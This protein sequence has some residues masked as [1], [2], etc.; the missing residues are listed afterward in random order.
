MPVGVHGWF[1]LD[2]LSSAAS[3]SPS[4]TQPA[5]KRRAAAEMESAEWWTEWLQHAAATSAA[6]AD[7]GAAAHPAAERCARRAGTSAHSEA[8]LAWLWNDAGDGATTASA[9]RRCAG[10]DVSASPLAAAAWGQTPWHVAQQ[11]ERR[12]RLAAAHGRAPQGPQLQAGGLSVGGTGLEPDADGAIRVG[13]LALRAV[14]LKQWQRRLIPPHDYHWIGALRLRR[15]VLWSRA[16][17]PCSVPRGER[18]LT[19]ARCVQWPR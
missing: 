2:A 3:P 19:C 8:Q 12:A 7:R 1:S 14:E 11:H 16:V 13:P 6:A 5:S 18:W 4:P 10:G 17:L 9:S 15:W